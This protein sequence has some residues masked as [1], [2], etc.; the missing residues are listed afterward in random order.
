MLKKDVYELTN[1]QKNIWQMDQVNEKNPSISHIL[2]V[3]KLKGNLDL[4]L[5]EKTLFTIVNSNDSFHIKFLKK[6]SNLL[7]FFEPTIS[8]NVEKFILDTDDISSVISKYKSIKIDLNT[9]FCFA[10]V[11]TPNFT[12]VV[13]KTHHII[14]DAWGMTQVAE[15]I[16]D[17]YNKL[18]SGETLVDSP[19]VSYLSLI[20]R[21]KDYMNSNKY[22]I[23]EKFWND[24][25]DRLSSSKL[26]HNT[27]FFDKKA[28]RYEQLLDDNLFSKI[29]NYC[30]TNKISEY[31]FFLGILSVYFYK[32]LNSDKLIFGTPFLNRQ[33]RLKE[34]EC[35]GMFV[36]TLPLFVDI[37]LNS[38]FSDL[39]KSI[40]STNLSLYKHSNFPF[41]KIQELYTKKTSDASALYE[42]GFSYQINQL[43]N[44]TNSQDLGECHWIFLDE[45]NNPLTIHISSLNHDKWIFYDYLLSCFDED[46]IKSMNNIILHLIDEV[47]SG[48]E[49][50]SDIDIL[51]NEDINMLEQFNNSG[52]FSASRLEKDMNV[53]SVFEDIVKKY[54]NNTAIICGDQ[55]ISYKDLNIRINQIT[56]EL[57]N[58]GIKNNDPVALF[59][60]KS[61]DMIASMFA[62]LKS[63]GCY[64]PILS[65]EDTFRINYILNDC[66]PK[67]ILTHKNYS[68][69][70]PDSFDVISVDNLELALINNNCNFNVKISPDNIA[71]IIYTS[72]STGNPKGTMVMH[73]NICSLRYSIEHDSLLK[74][75]SEDVSISLLK[76]SFDASGIDIYT[77]L[78]FGGSL[79]L[80]QKEEELNPE[81]VIRLMEKYHV[82]R[83][84]LIPKWIEHI[85]IQDKLLNADL[86]HLRILGTGGETLKP[87]ILQNLLEKYSNLKILNLYGPTETT[88]FTTCK[89]VRVYEMTHNYTSIGSP[90][91]GARL[92]VINKNNEFMPIGVEGELIIYEDDDSIKNIASGY[93][94]LPDQTEKKFI[95]LYNPILKKQVKA[96]KTGDVAKINKYLEIEFIGR[97]DDVVK[98][99]GGYLVALNEVSSR[100]QNLLGN[101]F[102]VYPVALPYKN[103]KAIVLFLTQKEENISLYNI[104]NFINKNISFYMKPKKIIELK[105]FPRNSSG[106]INRKELQSIASEFLENNKNNLVAPKTKTEILIFNYIKSLI[107]ADDFSITDDFLDDLGIDSLSLTSIYTFLE[108]YNITIQ[109]IYN[110]PNIKDL[111]Y[112]IDNNTS[113]QM[114]QDLSN[115]SDIKILNNVKPFDL[116]NV[117]ITGVTGFLGI[118]LLKELLL[119]KH[120][121]RIYPIIRNKINLNGKKR[122]RKMF[123]YYFPNEPNLIELANSKIEILNG[124]I[125]CFELGLEKDVYKKLQNTVTTVINSAA[126]VRHFVKPQQI[127]KDNVK[128]VCNLID[129]CGKNISFAHISTLSIAGFKGEDTEQKVF[130]ENTLYI[131][132]KFNY[133]P[134]IISKF[135]AEKEILLATNNSGLNATIFRLGNIMP[136]FNDGVFQQNKTQNVFMASLKSIIDSGV[137]ANEFLDIKLEFSPVDECSKFILSLINSNSSQSIYHILSNKEI[138]ISSLISLLKILNYDIVDVKLDVFLTELNKHSDEYTREYILNNNLNSYSLDITLNELNKLGLSWSAV[139]ISY[140]QKILSIIQSFDN[141]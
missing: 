7:Q 43:E 27:S 42:I 129:F 74:A 127:R 125:S 3:M 67:C 55:K 30:K 31:S 71:Y 15:Q 128:S 50:L 63:G 97:D 1:P 49:N 35:T 104:K 134:Y 141:N 81:K 126:N 96:Y 2:T 8:F 54:P 12:F 46:E 103:T 68:K 136:R 69:K 70:L 130:D 76:Y 5:L 77:S 34:L 111:A 137:I 140:L 72:G 20:D 18:S 44:H 91:F 95:N 94:N 110:N 51:S 36:S 58:L 138:S 45:Q 60:D 100:I 28:K 16:K 122:L 107:G 56:K 66:K 10:L 73:K 90:I 123:D 109:D 83:S 112:F 40:S 65:D 47:I 64:V 102:E 132:Q 121:K 61:I 78:L 57:L 11:S 39:C 87:Y 75:T 22:N 52:S 9:L 48:K 86:S 41:H 23:D 84:F 33:K 53:V 17:I 82:T 119:D 131:N 101:H 25:V 13:Y 133:N 135:E 98:V 120:V 37:S 88:M 32:T 93:L 79:V 14:S 89:D 116:S 85:S 29:S 114:L 99:N 4:N 113:N 139:N 118:H 106:K 62:V 124:D 6:G 105:E 108:D 38:S 59:F 24:Y 115:I 21:E 92:A 80:A 19:K 26:F 117:L